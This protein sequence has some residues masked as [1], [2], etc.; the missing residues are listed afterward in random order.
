MKQCEIGSL[1]VIALALTAGCGEQNYRVEVTGNGQ[2]GANIKTVPKDPAPPQVA[3]TAPTTTRVESLEEQNRKQLA[4]I[5]Q[6]QQ[7]LQRQQHEIQKLK[8]SPTTGPSSP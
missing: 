1:I 2:G 3:T 7:Q 4:Q 6:L 5:Q 8:Q